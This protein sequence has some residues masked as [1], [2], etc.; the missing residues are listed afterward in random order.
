MV[1][2]K[3]KC[4]CCGVVYERD[5]FRA[6]CQYMIN[7]HKCEEQ[8]IVDWHNSEEYYDLLDNH[9]EYFV[10]P[11]TYLSVKRMMERK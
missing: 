6:D 1:I 7:P 5:E 4:L 8:G 2:E 9:P 11:I 10:P 3:V